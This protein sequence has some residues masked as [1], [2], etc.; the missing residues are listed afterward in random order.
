MPAWAILRE[1]RDR[2]TLAVAAVAAVLPLVLLAPWLVSNE[3]RYGA[4]T[5]DSL[6]KQMQLPLL[7][8]TGQHYGLQS[9]LSGVGGLT[10][11]LLPQE[12]WSQYAGA[13]VVLRAAADRAAP[14]RRPGA[15]RLARRPRL[16]TLAGRRGARQ[17]CR[18][19]SGALTLAG[20][21]RASWPTGR[22]SFRAT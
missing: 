22:A 14:G 19:C 18:L 3:S 12:W 15:D 17:R 1:R 13:G 8:P 4:L 5:A 7:N 10:R 6:A 21:L 20:I 16:A 11:A 2:A 9:L